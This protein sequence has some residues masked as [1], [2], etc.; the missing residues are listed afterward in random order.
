MTEEQAHLFFPHEPHEDLEDLWEHRLFEQKQF[1]LTRPPL[2]KVWNAKI[3]K[4]DKQYEAYLVLTEQNRPLS[5]IDHSLEGVYNFSDQYI[6]A[7]HQFHK[8]RNDFKS[9][10]LQAQ[11]FLDLSEVIEEWLK[12]ENKFAQYWS[13]PSTAENDIEIL[14]GKEPDPMEFLKALKE[15]HEIIQSPLTKDLKTNYNILPEIVQKEV[16][17][18]T[19]LSKI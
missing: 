12:V 13:L 18:L 5:K 3:K 10:L 6:E 16:K 9:E 14:Q 17:R 1:F 19:L 7:F 4:L 2:A 8:L 15:G 11:T